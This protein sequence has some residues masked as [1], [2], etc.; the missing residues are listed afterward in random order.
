MKGNKSPGT[1]GITVEFYQYFWNDISDLVLS[2]FKTGFTKK[3]L[4]CEQKR[5]IIRLIPKKDKGQN[6]RPISLLN[7]DY[8]IIAHVLANRL[9]QSLPEVISK[10]QSGYLKNRNITLNIRTIYDI[11]ND[12]ENKNSSALLAFIDFEKA[13]D[14]LNWTFLQKALT[15]FGFGETFKLWVKILYS[16]IESCIINNGITSNY[17]EIKAGV[18]QG[19]P[20]SALL[21]LV[22]V[23]PL[24]IAIRNNN[25]IR[26]VHIGNKLFKIT[27]LADD[28]T[29]FL[30][31]ID[32]LKTVM[33]VLDN[34]RHTSGLN[35]N[36][37]KTEILQLGVPLT[38]NYT[39]L[40]LKW[41][42]EKIYALGSWFYKDHN[43]SVI[44]THEKRLDMLQSTL[45]L[46]KRRNLSWIGR[47]T[48]IKT[49]CIS[50]LNYT[51]SSVE[52][53]E[54]FTNRVETLLNDFLWNGK[55]PRVKQKVIYN[56]YDNGGL[57]MTNLSHFIKAQK[58]NWIKRLLQ[59]KETVPHEYVSK[60]LNMD[61]KDYLKCNIEHTDLPVELPMFYKQVLSA[62][63][64]IKTEP[65]NTDEVQREIIWTNKYIKVGTKTLFNK[66]L[67]ENGL[68]YIKDLLEDNGNLI[69]Y[70]TLIQQFG[71]NMTPYNYICLKHAIPKRWRKLLK[72]NNII[73][74]NPKQETVFLNMNKNVIPVAILK[75]KQ[76]YWFLNTQK[77]DQPSCIT[78][79]FDKY[80]IEFSPA[81]WKKIFML[82]KSLTNNTKLIEFQFKIIHR[83]YAS[84]SYVSN[85]DNT[86]SRVCI[87]CHVNNNIPHLFVDC[88]K[89][90]QFWKDMKIW[91]STVEGKAMPLKTI[92][93]IFGM[94]T[95]ARK[96][97]NF[98]ILHAKWYIHLNKQEDNH[99]N[100]AHFL[101]YLKNVLV[102]EKQVAVNQ[103]LIPV[104][105]ATFQNVLNH[106]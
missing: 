75:S 8:K 9:Q 34:F 38:S 10:D 16:D 66:K 57:R 63:F 83:V 68:I 61:L 106:V 62:W 22:A 69:S 23:E 64:S 48:V 105:N 74:I 30:N 82:S 90:D 88:I 42:K 73:N 25:D 79:W 40:N 35:L 89:V 51:I 58:I 95:S 28:T 36:K 41:E 26:G 24:A 92:D 96:S 33:K 59:N 97:I 70:E 12:K 27:Q 91:L 7:T 49:Q 44:E 72:S 3:V 53:P 94:I 31:D 39:L 29:L 98:C 104:F 19:C 85:F 93:I 17:F 99:I 2:S 76:V 43:I 87:L 103:K 80:L 13:F 65:K 81:Q 54:W 6:W 20:L 100:F 4:S 47:I 86:V 71:N 52:T 11:I 84:D 60:F 46:W 77:I 56:D 78:K 101:L 15:Q 67:Y 21:F 1:D 50:K 14:K 5:G 32:S 102:I 45:K 37:K 18:R 55:P